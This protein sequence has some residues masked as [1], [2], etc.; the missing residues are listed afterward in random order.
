MYVYAIN[1]GTQGVVRLSK[2]VA[3]STTT[4]VSSTAATTTADGVDYTFRVR[5]VG[6][7]IQVWKGETQ[8]ISYS[9]STAEALVFN[10]ATKWGLRL[11]KGGSPATAARVSGLSMVQL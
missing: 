6:D 10:I 2:V 5:A 9:L 8:F 4:L 1:N 11:L 3:G 7:A